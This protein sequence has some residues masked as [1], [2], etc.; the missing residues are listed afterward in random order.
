MSPILKATKVLTREK[1]RPI[2]AHGLT[3]AYYASDSQYVYGPFTCREDAIGWTATH[4]TTGFVRYFSLGRL[5]RMGDQ[6]VA[7]SVGIVL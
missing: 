7:D 6:D 4:T 1:A 5:Q 2:L 3:V